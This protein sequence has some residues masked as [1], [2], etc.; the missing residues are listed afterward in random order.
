MLLV[1]IVLIGERWY[2]Y[3]A[4]GESPYDEMGIELNS[5]MPAP[6][7]TWGCARISERFP[8]IIASAGPR[9][10]AVLLLGCAR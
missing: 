5:H 4:Y 10:D 3:V 1:A 2:K 7:R 8:G 9:T 6:L